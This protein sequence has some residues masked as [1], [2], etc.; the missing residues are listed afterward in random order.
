[1]KI[2]KIIT[3]PEWNNEPTYHAGDCIT[4]VFKGTNEDFHNAILSVEQIEV[5]LSMKEVMFHKLPLTITL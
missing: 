4:E 5:G 3:K 2:Y 1:M